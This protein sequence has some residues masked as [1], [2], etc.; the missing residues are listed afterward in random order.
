MRRSVKR[1][2]AKQMFVCLSDFWVFL[3]C[4][5][6]SSED[7]SKDFSVFFFFGFVFSSWAFLK[8]VLRIFCILGFGSESSNRLWKSSNSFKHILVPKNYVAW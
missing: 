5:V 2:T 6:Y 8:G 4:L 1:K 3:V 7:L